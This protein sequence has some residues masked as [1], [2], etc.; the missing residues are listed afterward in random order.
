MGL[1]GRIK[2]I[3]R[4]SITCKRCKDKLESKS[5]L[6]VLWCDCGHVGIQGGLHQLQRLYGNVNDTKLEY[7]DTSVIE[8]EA[9]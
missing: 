2:R 7:E 3:V 5:P 4:N 9:A 1:P 6:G 8:K